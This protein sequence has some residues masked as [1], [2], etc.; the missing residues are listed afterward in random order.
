MT[1]KELIREKNS[2]IDKRIK[3]MHP[4]KRTQINSNI[5]SKKSLKVMGCA[6]H[7]YPIHNLKQY[8]QTDIIDG[9]YACPVCPKDFSDRSGFRH[10]WDNNHSEVDIN[11][12]LLD[13]SDD[14]Y[15]GFN[16]EVEDLKIFNKEFHV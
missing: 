12:N 13:K 5:A 16:F 10:H 3:E 7:Y 1:I 6:F 8:P 14:C 4:I 11:N 15:D 2:K 9:R